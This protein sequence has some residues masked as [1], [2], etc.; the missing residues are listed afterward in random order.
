MALT[1]VVYTDTI[2]TFSSTL[3]GVGGQNPIHLSTVQN[4]TFTVNIPREN[5]NAMGFG[6]TVDRPQ[7]TAADATCEFSYIPELD[8][9]TPST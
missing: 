2:L 7:L 5:V 1:R 6:G 3:L 8:I 9:L 4:A